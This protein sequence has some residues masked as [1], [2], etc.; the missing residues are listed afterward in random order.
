TGARPFFLSRGY[1][2][3]VSGPRLVDAATDLAREVGDEP[4]LLARVAP[5]VVASDRVAGAEL[6]LLHGATVIVM[7]DGLQNPS[8]KKDFTLAVIDARRGLGN[9]CVFPA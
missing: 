3:S 5:T 6:A 9:T 4:L 7:D 8:L 2:G 1:G